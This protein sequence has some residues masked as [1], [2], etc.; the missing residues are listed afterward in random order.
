[1]FALRVPLPSSAWC[2]AMRFFSSCCRCLALFFSLGGG[3]GVGGGSFGG[4]G[5]WAFPVG[6]G[7]RLLSEIAG[8]PIHTK[9]G[10]PRPGDVRDSRADITRASAKLGFTPRTSLRDGLGRTLAW[11]RTQRR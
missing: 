10:E 8:V 4:G 1:L 7:P 11:Y 6:G 2:D 9:H 5:G 3:R